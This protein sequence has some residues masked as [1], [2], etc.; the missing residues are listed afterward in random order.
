MDEYLTGEGG[1]RNDF[2][3]QD[4]TDRTVTVVAAAARIL[5]IVVPAAPMLQIGGAETI[6]ILRKHFGHSPHF[7]VRN[8]RTQLFS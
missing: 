5:E 2:E 3:L 4:T 7:F 1:K 8:V 6:S